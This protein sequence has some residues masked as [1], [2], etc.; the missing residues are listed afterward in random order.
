MKIPPFFK[1]IS[2]N[3]TDFIFI[4][5][6]VILLFI[7][8]S[9]ISKAKMS[10]RENRMLANK[11]EFIIDGKINNEYGSQYDTWFQDRF[12]GREQIIRLYYH[13]KNWIQVSNNPKVLV[14]KDGFCLPRATI[15]WK[16]FKT[17][18]CF[19]TKNYNISLNTFL[20]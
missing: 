11:P 7:P 3:K 14:G 15:L 19:Q 2:K 10:H 8:M 20:I 12:Y 16:T 9:H 17:K 18:T 6:F 13:I 4:C 1:E 5:I